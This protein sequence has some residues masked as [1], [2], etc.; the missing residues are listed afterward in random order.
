[1][2]RSDD[3]DD[4]D[5]YDDDDDDDD[6]DEDEDENSSES[7][8]STSMPCLRASLVVGCNLERRRLER[9]SDVD[10]RVVGFVQLQ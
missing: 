10:S 9:M 5:D 3:D 8:L 6:Y 7:P 4:D 1:M 2:G